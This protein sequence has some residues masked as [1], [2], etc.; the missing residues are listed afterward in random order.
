MRLV[1]AMPAVR[2]STKASGWVSSPHAGIQAPRYWG[3][4]GWPC[5]RAMSCMFSEPYTI[6]TPMI[7]APIAISAEIIRAAARW[8]PS[9][10]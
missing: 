7:E 4:S 9:R 1:D 5:P 3:R 6:T 10:A 8:P 2:K